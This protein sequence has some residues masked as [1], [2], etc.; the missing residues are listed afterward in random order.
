MTE[1][2]VRKKF[3]LSK[4]TMHSLRGMRNDREG[5][6]TEGKDWKRVVKDNKLMVVYLKSGIKKLE[7]R[8]KK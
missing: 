5:I 7:N 1:T 6:L 8:Y 3:N 2:E 4:A